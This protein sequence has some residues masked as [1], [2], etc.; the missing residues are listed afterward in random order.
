MGRS[1]HDTCASRRQSR[2]GV[3][4]GPFRGAAV[5]GGGLTGEGGAAVGVE[6][7]IERSQV[8]VL[9]HEEARVLVHQAQESGSVLHTEVESMLEELGVDRVQAEE[10][11]HLLED[12]HVEVVE[13]AEAAPPPA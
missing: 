3:D 10:L 4:A 2:G 8:A 12:L 6:E 5:Q 7:R 13:E 11:Y 9:D 1:A